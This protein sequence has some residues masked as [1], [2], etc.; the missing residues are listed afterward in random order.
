MPPVTVPEKLCTATLPSLFN[1][2]K[3][4]N[5]DVVGTEFRVNVFADIEEADNESKENK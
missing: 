3:V 2:K 1:T 5:P 4:V